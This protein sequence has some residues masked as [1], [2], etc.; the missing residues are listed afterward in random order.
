MT[1]R[2]RSQ[3]ITSEDGQTAV[4]FALVAPILI[5]LLLGI[6]QIGI[7]FNHYLAVT[8]AARAGARKAIV[9]R[10]A[11]ATQA[12]IEASVRS[13]AVDLD[14]SQLH[15]VVSAPP[16]ASGGD[17]TVTVTYPYSISLLGVVVASGNLTSKMTDRVE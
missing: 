13:A 15:V 17:V 6:L 16:W 9:A 3:D 8:D 10:I 7:A 12:D 11:G 4:E 5:V 2:R 1:H 14:Q